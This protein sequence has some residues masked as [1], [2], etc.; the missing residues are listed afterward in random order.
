MIVVVVAVGSEGRARIS[1]GLKYLI[2]L[3]KLALEIRGSSDFDMIIRQLF[4]PENVVKKE[5]G[6]KDDYPAQNE[7]HR[8]RCR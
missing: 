7:K 5:G 2:L 3:P 1:E 4:D 8:P 6:R